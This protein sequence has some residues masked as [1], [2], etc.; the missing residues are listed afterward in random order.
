MRL[1]CSWF[2]GLRKN[3][4]KIVIRK[5]IK[6]G[7]FLS[8]LLQILVQR[9]LDVLQFLIG[10]SELLKK[11]FSAANLHYIRVLFCQDHIS[12]PYIINT[13]EFFAF[14][15]QLLWDISRIKNRLQIHPVSLA[16]H[17]FF[18]H[19]RN[20]LQFGIPWD[21]LFFKRLFEWRK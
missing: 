11:S 9:F 4:K 15:R 1:N 20:C 17:P 16:F 18:H 13:S 6:S 3:L 10:I 8:F 2:F 21:Y 19:I 7:K 5:E 12:L 14:S